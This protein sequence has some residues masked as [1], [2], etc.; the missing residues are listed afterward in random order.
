MTSVSWPLAE[1]LD[2]FSPANPVEVLPNALSPHFLSED[3]ESNRSGKGKIGYFGHLTNSWF[4]WESLIE[5]ANKR[6]DYEFEIIGHSEPEDLHLP[7]NVSLLGPRTHPEINEIAAEWDVAIIPFR[8]GKLS[9]AVDPIKIYEYLALG[10]PTVSFRMPQIDD[11]PYTRTV[12]SIEEF[13]DSLDFF[14]Q[15]EI[16]KSEIEEWLGSNTW[17]DR[18]DRM[19]ELS[20]I[21]PNDGITSIGE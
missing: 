8:V 11:Y 21:S 3:F 18:V 19:L 9:D 17:G 14:L 16:S 12:T 10:L 2:G 15:E 13:C 4:D 5:I 1:K 6:T 20:V 7:R